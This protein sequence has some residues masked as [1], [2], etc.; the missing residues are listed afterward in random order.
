MCGEATL[1]LFCL[2]CRLSVEGFFWKSHSLLVLRSSSN[3]PFLLLFHTS[4]FSYLEG[5][6]QRLSLICACIWQSIYLDWSNQSLMYNTKNEQ[7]FIWTGSIWRAAF[8][9]IWASVKLWRLISTKS[10]ISSTKKNTNPCFLQIV[11]LDSLKC[12]FY[13]QKKVAGISKLH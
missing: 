2:C 6:W 10:W 5:S 9:L 1:V 12:L 3:L 11:S 13:T 7:W 4:H 8:L